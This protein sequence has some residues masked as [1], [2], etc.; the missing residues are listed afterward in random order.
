MPRLPR[1]EIDAAGIELLKTQPWRGNVRELQNVVFRLALMSREEMIDASTVS[2]VL[3]EAPVERGGSRSGGFDE[4][5]S[6]WL[7]FNEPANGTLYH[8]ALAAFEKPLFE[9]V[10]GETGGNQLRAAQM[11]GIN[12]NTL[13][14]RLGELRID[15][16]SFSRRS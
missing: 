16:D 10:L 5:L 9:H 13:R 15:P 8:S 2:E 12:R 4:A 14:K 7:G 1:R 3:K 11:L 6:H